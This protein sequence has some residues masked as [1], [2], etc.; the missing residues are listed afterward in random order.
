MQRDLK[1]VIDGSVGGGIGTI[2]MSAVMMAAQKTDIMGGQPP[3]LITAAALDAASIRRKVDTQHVL[4]VLMH[5]GF[6][7]VTGAFFGLLHRRLR[8]PIAA[9]PHG[10]VFGTLVW[11]VSYKGW[12][13]ALGIIPPPERDRPGRPISMVL[14]HW[15]YGLILGLI[16]DRRAQ[17]K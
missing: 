2:A 1:A 13:P 3:E 6:G 10:V 7:V 11:A 5:F 4:A 12:V 16:I 9:A 8:P 17:T 15:V 14:A